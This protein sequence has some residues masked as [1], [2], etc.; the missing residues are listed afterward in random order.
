[1]L[2]SGS[3]GKASTS[4]RR[5][6]FR[7]SRSSAVS[8]RAARIPAGPHADSA[9]WSQRT[10]GR[11]RVGG[12]GDGG[13]YPATTSLSAGAAYADAGAEA[14]LDLEMD[15]RTGDRCLTSGAGRQ[16]TSARAARRVPLGNLAGTR[17]SRVTSKHLPAVVR[18]PGKRCGGSGLCGGSVHPGE[19]SGITCVRGVSYQRNSHPR[20]AWF[21][22]ICPLVRAPSCSPVHPEGRLSGYVYGSGCHGTR[23]CRHIAGPEL[24]RAG[25]ARAADVGR[26]STT[27]RLATRQP[28]LTLERPPSAYTKCGNVRSAPA[29]DYRSD[30][31]ALTLL[32]CRTQERATAKAVSWSSIGR[33]FLA[34]LRSYTSGLAHACPDLSRLSAR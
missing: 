17:G 7:A 31:P 5:S 23:N 25:T 6:R 10:A 8:V 21:A 26:Q 18:R 29:A 15:Y 28:H 33:P 4:A 27:S 16:S 3:I 32:A 12:L 22:V 11:R 19:H 20:I 24:I 34:V 2:R 13:A 9:A 30:D 14:A 1:V